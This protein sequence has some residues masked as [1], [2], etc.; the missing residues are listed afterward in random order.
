MP[1]AADGTPG[2]E[3][4]TLALKQAGLQGPG[5]FVV[6]GFTEGQLLIRWR[7]PEEAKALGL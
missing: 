6:T 5:G 1:R 7:T 2:A 4:V 3:L